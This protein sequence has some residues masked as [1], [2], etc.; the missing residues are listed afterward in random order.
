MFMQ[1]V[2]EARGNGGDVMLGGD[3]LLVTLPT[4]SKDIKTQQLL[5]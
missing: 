4:G 3:G 5:R 2:S 1:G